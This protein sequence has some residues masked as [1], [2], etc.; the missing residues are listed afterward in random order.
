MGALRA[1]ANEF[2]NGGSRCCCPRI[3][4]PAGQR[5]FRQPNLLNKGVTGRIDGAVGR[6]EKQ[7]IGEQVWC[8]EQIPNWHRRSAQ[9]DVAALRASNLWTGLAVF[10]DASRP[11]P[12]PR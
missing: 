7:R 1:G 2:L 10:H 11:K 5:I 4:A 9:L 3:E 12:S 8:S 6:K